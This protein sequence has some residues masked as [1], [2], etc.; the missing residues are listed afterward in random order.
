MAIKALLLVVVITIPLFFCVYCQ[1]SPFDLSKLIALY[2][3]VGLMLIIW[4][5]KSLLILR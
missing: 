3:L 5:A 2:I 4:F 1:K